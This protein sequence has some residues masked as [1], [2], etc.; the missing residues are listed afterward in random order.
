MAVTNPPQVIEVVPRR[1]FTLEH[2]TLLRLDSPAVSS[3][4]LSASRPTSYR[5]VFSSLPTLPVTRHPPAH[6]PPLSLSVRLLE[7]LYRGTPRWFLTRGNLITSDTIKYPGDEGGTLHVSGAAMNSEEFA[8]NCRGEGQYTTRGIV[9]RAVMGT[10]KDCTRERYIREC[11]EELFSREWVSYRTVRHRRRGKHRCGRY[12]LASPLGMHD[13]FIFK[14]VNLSFIYRRGL[15]VHTN[16]GRERERK[17]RGGEREKTERNK[18]SLVRI[19]KY[20]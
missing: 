4:A 9:P 8:G 6:Q 7:H 12:L 2:L 13:G 14:V 3:T 18:I 11:G 20:F 10:F 16:R 19:L 5:I 17:R 15:R 1:G